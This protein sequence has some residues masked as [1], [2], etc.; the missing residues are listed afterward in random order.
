MAIITLPEN[1]RDYEDTEKALRIFPNMKEYIYAHE[2]TAIIDHLR[3]YKPWESLNDNNNEPYI[4]QANELFKQFFLQKFDDNKYCSDS[5]SVLVRHLFEYVN[6]NNILTIDSEGTLLHEKIEMLEWVKR[7]GSSKDALTALT[8]ERA[9]DEFGHEVH[10]VAIEAEYSF[11]Q[12]ICN[13]ITG[14]ELP[15]AAFLY[16]HPIIE[17][18]EHPNRNKLDNIFRYNKHHLEEKVTDEQIKKA[19]NFFEKG[20]YKY[21]NKKI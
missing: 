3:K 20:G 17:A 16:A 19:A 5:Q 13:E 8:K 6:N 15:F 10:K 4:E 14:E 7:Y 11:Y 12:Y 21:I 18:L 9:Y 2:N 1:W